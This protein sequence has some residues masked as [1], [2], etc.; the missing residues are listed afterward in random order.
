MAS[1]R[2]GWHSPC[3]HHLRTI[4]A[5]IHFRVSAL[6]WMINCL[7]PLV[8]A[9]LLIE[10]MCAGST[11]S[12]LLGLAVLA[13]SPVMVIPHW[14]ASSHTN[15]PVCWTLVLAPKHSAKHRN[16]KTLMGSHRLRVAVAILCKNE[17][18]CPYCN[19]STALELPN[20]RHRAT[21]RWLQ[22]D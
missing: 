3:M 13:L 15:C 5:I 19:E 17:F 12:A 2:P 8:A 1:W 20:T 6:I 18:R 14:A 7:L 9:G 4:P 21:N 22:L 16:A 11:H 10:L